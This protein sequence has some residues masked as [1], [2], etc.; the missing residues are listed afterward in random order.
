MPRARRATRATTGRTA[1]TSACSSR[2]RR[3]RLVVQRGSRRGPQ[4]RGELRLAGGFDSNTMSGAIGMVKTFD[5][6]AAV[7]PHV[8][9]VGRARHEASERRPAPTIHVAV[10][11]AVDG[12]EL[13]VHEPRLE[14][15]NNGGTTLDQ[16]F[17]FD[18]VSGLVGHAGH[19]RTTRAR[20]PPRWRPSSRTTRTRRSSPCRSTTGA[21]ARGPSLSMH[22][23]LASTTWC[24]GSVTAHALRLRRLAPSRSRR[25]PR[26]RQDAAARRPVKEWTSDVVRP[27]LRGVRGRGDV[28]ALARMT[29]TT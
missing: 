20:R 24:S 4:C 19:A 21:R 5:R 12:H 18:A 17:V 1:S 26:I 3:R 15:V 16:P 9:E 6:R 14:P 7:E 11:G 10:V 27:L 28:Q 2:G 25:L 13:G 8:A 22:S 29:T 23:A